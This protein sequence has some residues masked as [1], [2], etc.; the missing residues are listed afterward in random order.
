VMP[1]EPR[2]IGLP[3]LAPSSRQPVT[4]YQPQFVIHTYQN[5]ISI[6]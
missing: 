1:T 2:F 3:C 5:S 6:L 4:S